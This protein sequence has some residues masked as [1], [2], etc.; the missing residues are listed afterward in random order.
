MALGT[1]TSANG[2][3]DVGGGKLS[4]R[5]IECCGDGGVIQVPQFVTAGSRGRLTIEGF[6]KELVDVV[7][8]EVVRHSGLDYELR[9]NVARG[10]WPYAIWVQLSMVAALDADT[11]VAAAPDCYKVLGIKPG[12]GISDVER[13]FFQLV[14]IVHP[15]RGGTVAEFTRVRNAY[16]EALAW[17]GGR[18]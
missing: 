11:A 16:L 2:S 15:D 4:T 1:R 5:V 17:V 8:G 7:V 12:S 3:L 10:S 18:R 14:R 6:P 13:A 9:F